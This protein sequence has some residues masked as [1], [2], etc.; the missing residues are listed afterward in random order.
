MCPCVKWQTSI[1]FSMFCY[2][3]SS[4]STVTETAAS[5]MRRFNLSKSLGRGGTYTKS[6]VTVNRNHVVSIRE[7]GRATSSDSSPY[8][9]LEQSSDLADAHSG[10]HVELHEYWEVPLREETFTVPLSN[11]IQIVVLSNSHSKINVSESV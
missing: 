3:R 10:V 2:T 4:M 1:L 11:K 5:K 8:V 6:C 9:R 7:F